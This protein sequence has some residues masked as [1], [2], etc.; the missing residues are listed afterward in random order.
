MYSHQFSTRRAT[1]TRSKSKPPGRRPQLTNASGFSL[2]E[3]LVVMIIIGILAGI[4][5]P[6]FLG[7]KAKAFDAQAKELVRSAQTAAETIATEADGSYEHVT[8]KEIHQTEPSV[9]IVATTKEAY[10][11]AATQG[12]HE[13]S[14]TVKATNGDEFTVAKNAKGEMSRQCT[15]PVLKTGCSGGESSS[16]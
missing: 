1:G 6:L 15:S 8:A 5:I 3:L 4:G 14:L 13:Y 11:S 7:Q 12:A 10:L 16:W 2:I 9:P